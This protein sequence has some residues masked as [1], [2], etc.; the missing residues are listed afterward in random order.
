MNTTRADNTPPGDAAPAS[1]EQPPHAT[2]GG[3]P[4]PRPGAPDEEPEADASELDFD[5]NG[6]R[7]A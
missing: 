7:S 2:D 6:S 5:G 3:K 4:A 1:R